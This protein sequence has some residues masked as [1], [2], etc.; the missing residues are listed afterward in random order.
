MLWSAQHAIK[1]LIAMRGACCRIA[2]AAG[3][4][5]SGWMIY[6]IVYCGFAFSSSMYALI[7]WF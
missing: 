1:A 3:A 6:A 2:S 5:R 7:G 4:D